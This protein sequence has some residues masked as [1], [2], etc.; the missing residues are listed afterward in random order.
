MQLTACNIRRSAEQ[1]LAELLDRLRERFSG[2]TLYF[3]FP[4]ENA[5]AI[6]ALIAQGFL[7]AEAAW[8]HVFSFPSGAPL[9]IDGQVE[10]IGRHNFDAFRAVYHPAPDA[11]WDA[12]RILQTI[13][14]W[15]IFVYNQNGKP[16]AS[17]IFRAEGGAYEIFALDGAQGAA[18]TEAARSLLTAALRAC[19][20]MGAAHLTYFCPDGQRQLLKELGFRCVGQYMLYTKTL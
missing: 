8:N 20:D 6:D 4:A 16:T 7:L 3:G 14:D 11:Y 5:R 19:E 9:E 17:V 2:Y 18:A 15:T 1:A 13:D 12:A 10:K